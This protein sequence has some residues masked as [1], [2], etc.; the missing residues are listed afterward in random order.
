M[1]ILTIESN[2]SSLLFEKLLNRELDV[3]I[4]SK[5]GEM[6]PDLT[7]QLLYQKPVVGIY[8]HSLVERLRKIS[9]PLPQGEK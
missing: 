8:H 1:T 5:S 9:R 2:K 3:I 6:H 4:T 7:S